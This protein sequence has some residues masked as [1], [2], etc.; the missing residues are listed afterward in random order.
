MRVPR[1]PRFA[2]DVIGL[3][4]ARAYKLRDTALLPPTGPIG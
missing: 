3:A 4:R 1:N 2:L